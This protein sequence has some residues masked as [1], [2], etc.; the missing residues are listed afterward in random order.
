VDLKPR[1]ACCPRISTVCN[2]DFIYPCAEAAARIV[3]S[4]PIGFANCCRKTEHGTLEQST[5]RHAEL[6]ERN[7]RRSL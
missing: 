1:R 7:N 6:C 3:D 2:F 4:Q 5:L